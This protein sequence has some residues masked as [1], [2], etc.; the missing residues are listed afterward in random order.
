MGI[1]F[2]SLNSNPVLSSWQAI[3][4]CF[5]DGYTPGCEAAGARKNPWTSGAA[6]DATPMP[7]S[8]HSDITLGLKYVIGKYMYILHIYIYTYVSRIYIYIQLGLL[9]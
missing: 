8:L 6:V 7:W 2:R 3:I 5:K 1:Q 9:A 4:A